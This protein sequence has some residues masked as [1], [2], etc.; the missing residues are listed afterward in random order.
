M[1][2]ASLQA[3]PQESALWGKDTSAQEIILYPDDWI[4][5]GG[6]TTRFTGH[7]SDFYEYNTMP[8][9]YVHGINL[10]AVGSSTIKFKVAAHNKQGTG[11]RPCQVI[12]H[13]VLHVADL[14]KMAL[15]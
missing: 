5:D 11:T 3:Q 8:P 14:L 1:I 4:V 10:Y 13:R 15:M 12:L 2:Q 7:R 9:R 6:A